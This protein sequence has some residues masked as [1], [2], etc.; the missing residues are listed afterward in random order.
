MKKLLVSFL[1]TGSLIL[2]VTLGSL[3]VFSESEEILGNTVSA[4]TVD[5]DLR[6]LNSGE[7]SK[8]LN[9]SGLIPGQWTDWGRAVIYNKI[10][11]TDVKVFFYVKD[12]TGDACPKVNLQVTTGHA[13]G[14]ER[15]FDVYNGPINGVKG[16][17]SRVE[18]TG[19]I[20]PLL[21]PNISAVVQQHAQLD[22]SAGNSYMGTSCTWTE[23]FVAE[24]PAP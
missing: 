23:V 22:G 4:A 13:G 24:T 11:S 19:Y 18:I 17:G 15:A 10:N 8:P 14:N 12:V 5:I 16:P 20:F 7:I 3:A 2:S 1:V 9:V 21:A 6:S